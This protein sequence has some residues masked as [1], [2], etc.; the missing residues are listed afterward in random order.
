[1]ACLLTSDLLSLEQIFGATHRKL[2]R[3]SEGPPGPVTNKATK[4]GRVC[5][6]N[7]NTDAHKLD[8]QS[9]RQTFLFLSFSVC[10]LCQI[11]RQLEAMLGGTGRVPRQE[12]AAGSPLAS[13]DQPFNATYPVTPPPPSSLSSGLSGLHRYQET[14]LMSQNP[15]TDVTDP[16]SPSGPEHAQS[17]PSGRD[18]GKI[19]P[20]PE[21]ESGDSQAEAARTSEATVNSVGESSPRPRGG[22]SFFGFRAAV[23]G[24]TVSVQRHGAGGKGG[25]GSHLRP[26][27][28]VQ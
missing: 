13:D 17:S 26:D 24:K 23:R 22:K 28:R 11:L 1:M 27:G 4:V 7:A 14:P 9:K 2:S 10:F 18:H 21:E 12:V 15:S 19:P 25:G 20:S 16:P 5:V 3:L 8:R 6:H